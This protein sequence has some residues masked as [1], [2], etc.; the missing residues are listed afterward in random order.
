[1]KKMPS[2]SIGWNRVSAV[3]MLGIN[4]RAS[5]ENRHQRTH[6]GTHIHSCHF[7]LLGRLSAEFTSSLTHRFTDLAIAELK[8]SPVI[9]QLLN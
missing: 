9:W 1:M 3:D 4:R 7:N 2:S 6:E 5:V 8:I